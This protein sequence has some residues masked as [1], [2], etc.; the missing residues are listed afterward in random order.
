MRKLLIG[1]VVLALVLAGADVVARRV[2]EGKIEQR[3]AASS[4]RVASVDAH[5]RSFPFVGRLLASGSVPVVDVDLDEVESRS[6]TFTTVA[7]HLEGVELDRRA[8]RARK[9]ELRRID[10]GTVTLE[11]DASGLTRALHVPVS[12]TGGEVRV[13]TGGRTLSA[14]PSVGGEA[15]VLQVAGVAP[16]TVPV[17]RTSL[18]ACV[19]AQVRI[20]GERVR[21][22]CDVDEVPPGLRG[23]SAG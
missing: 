13:L 19:A 7:V 4:Q 16:L 18:I 9:I 14:R 17:K 8:L 23:A 5:I 1:L 3:A 6:V 20:E 12:I 10:R 2:A 11:L 22:M 15:L 21:L